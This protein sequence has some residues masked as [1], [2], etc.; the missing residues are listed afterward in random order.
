MHGGSNKSWTSDSQHAPCLNQG[1]AWV[2]KVEE[3]VLLTAL[4]THFGVADDAELKLLH[5]EVDDLWLLLDTMGSQ[6]VL[7]VSCGSFDVAAADARA[8]VLSHVAKTLQQPMTPHVTSTACVAL[9]L[10]FPDCSD[11][12]VEVS[13]WIPGED[14]GSWSP[15][16]AYDA[17]VALAIL[18]KAFADVTTDE[19]ERCMRLPKYS[20]E[21]LLARS[22]RLSTRPGW[23]KVLNDMAALR[24][25]NM[26][27]D[28]TAFVHGDVHRENVVL[29]GAPVFIYFEDVLTGPRSYDVASLCRSLERLSNKDVWRN[30]AHGYESVEGPT[31]VWQL[32]AWAAL[33]DVGIAAHLDH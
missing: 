17:G 28:E 18:H 22:L 29:N 2:K 4:R 26:F 13:S 19:D 11:V 16:I 7:R 3:S 32:S 27:D 30:A 1:E 20:A 21:A 31:D 6:S 10:Q 15:S 25:Q 23:P 5:S 9:R 33:R 8:F 14:I 24:A 12:W